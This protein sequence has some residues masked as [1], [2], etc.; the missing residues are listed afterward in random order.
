MYYAAKI[1]DEK[2]KFR[3][4]ANFRHKAKPRKED[5]EDPKEMTDELPLDLDPSESS[6]AGYWMCFKFCEVKPV[7]LNQVVTLFFKQL[8]ELEF[9]VLHSF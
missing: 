2:L 4:E 3:C 7:V 1:I 9:E 6:H 8:E 5:P